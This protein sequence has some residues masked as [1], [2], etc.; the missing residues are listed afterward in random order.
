MTAA[1]WP[2]SRCHRSHAWY[3]ALGGCRKPIFI[4]ALAVVSL[5]VEWAM[6]SFRAACLQPPVEITV[7][8]VSASRGVSP[9][10]F[11]VST[12]RTKTE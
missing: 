1:R 8:I 10:G 3:F 2:A 7:V 12:L 6:P 9:H 5:T 11:E 4:P